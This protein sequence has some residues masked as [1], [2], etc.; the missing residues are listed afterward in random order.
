MTLWTLGIAMRGGATKLGAELDALADPHHR[1]TKT[2]TLWRT[3]GAKG[4]SG[5]LGM[6]VCLETFLDSR[7]SGRRRPR[8]RR[9]PVS[10]GI[11]V[12]ALEQKQ[13]G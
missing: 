3:L 2:V 10:S 13:R 7:R 11:E 8:A 6:V 1:L 12:V 9:P 4:H 5:A